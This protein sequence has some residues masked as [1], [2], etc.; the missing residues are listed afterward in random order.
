MDATRVQTIYNEYLRNLMRVLC[1]NAWQISVRTEKLDEEVAGF[2]DANFEYLRATISIDPT[3]V[4]TEEEVLTVLF[5]ELLH[6]AFTA[7]AM[8]HNLARKLSTSEAATIGINEAF[9]NAA[10][11][12]VHQLEYAFKV[13]MEMSVKKIASLGARTRDGVKPAK[14]KKKKKR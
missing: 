3:E 10:E 7:Y 1:L 6:L 12:S 14:K 4:D 13:G 5:H 2:F 11:I 9:R 8:P